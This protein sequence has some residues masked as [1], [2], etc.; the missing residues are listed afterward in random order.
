MGQFLAFRVDPLHSAGNYD[1]NIDL[2]ML[3]SMI[4]QNIG[5]MVM[6]P[7]V[8]AAPAPFPMLKQQSFAD[9]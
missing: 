9:A 6:V 7:A 2:Y 1:G 4:R 8:P 5:T 3:I